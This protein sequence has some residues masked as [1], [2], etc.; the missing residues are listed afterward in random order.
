MS[1]SFWI[2]SSGV[3]GIPKRPWATGL[4]R[5]WQRMPASNN[6][7][8]T[9]LISERSDEENSIFISSLLIQ[10]RAGGASAQMEELRAGAG[11]FTEEDRTGVVRFSG[12]QVFKLS[13]DAVAL[14]PGEHGLIEAGSGAQRRLGLLRGNFG[15]GLGRRLGELAFA[16]AVTEVNNH[17]DDEPDKQPQPSFKRQKSHER[18]R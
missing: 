4:W 15:A 12:C 1:P 16:H 9:R 8:L 18:Q 7:F 3:E 17:A 5:N 10:S 2:Q 11:V 6:F 14:F 13:G